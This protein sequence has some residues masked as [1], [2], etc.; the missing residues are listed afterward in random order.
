[1]DDGTS[2][3]DGSPHHP[4]PFQRSPISRLPCELLAEIFFYL[5][6]HPGHF[7]P[8]CCGFLAEWLAIIHVCSKWRK[9]AF[10]AKCLWTNVIFSD[11]HIA[12][13]MLQRARG[14]PLNLSLEHLPRT[15]RPPIVQSYI[16]NL[17]LVIRH[18]SGNIRTVQLTLSVDDL[19]DIMRQ[20]EDM[21][22]T[23][24]L[25]RFKLSVWNP[26]GVCDI[27]LSLVFLPHDLFDGQYPQLRSLSLSNI[28]LPVKTY[29]FTQL[30]QIKL[31]GIL[32]KEDQKI[33]F[34]C[35]LNTLEPLSPTLQYIQLS[36]TLKD[37]YPTPSSP[38]RQIVLRDLHYLDI[39]STGSNNE[40][41]LRCLK[42]PQ[43]PI[44]L[45]WTALTR[46]SSQ[47]SL[48]SPVSA[49]YAGASDAVLRALY[50]NFRPYK[51]HPFYEIRCLF[52]ESAQFDD[53]ENEESCTVARVASHDTGDHIA[54]GEH[55]ATD[56][57]RIFDTV[58]LDDLVVLTFKCE[59]LL[60]DATQCSI[61]RT[62]RLARNVREPDIEGLSQA[63]F[64]RKVE[65]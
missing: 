18:S 4:K 51:G 21:Q 43:R 40:H 13:A 65:T 12:R 39:A 34:D 54:A 59:Y 27:P 9:V 56:L 20:L 38:H 10:G 31:D 42:L 37:C 52:R 22:F 16:E 53:L 49:Q 17:A 5:I 6:G 47:L 36:H 19:Q 45:L 28:F 11:S 64:N 25:E 33:C 32:L 44:K 41:L 7:H 26:R 1:M 55:V 62:L 3:V 2:V 15:H 57:A 60:N 50:I 63:V 46:S 14:M 61:L 23:S 30:T 48:L 24:H 8:D 35:L 58:L 29:Q